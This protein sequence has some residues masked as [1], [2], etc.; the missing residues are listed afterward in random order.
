MMKLKDEIA[1]ELIQSIQKSGSEILI[2]NFYFGYYEFDVFRMLDNGNIYE[3][4]IKTSRADFKNDFTK[5]RKVISDGN[6]IEVGKHEEIKFG[7]YSANK[8]FFVV[9]E[10]LIAPE[11]VPGKLGLIY[12]H[13]ERFTMHPE[14]Y[15]IRFEM[16]KAPKFINKEKIEIDHIGLLRKMAF[17]E[18]NLRLKIYEITKQKLK[19]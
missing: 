5:K 13:K 7:K 2:P 15:L 14:K 17:R 16:V 9:P 10:G 3:Y 6:I 12:F 11:E 4:E 1:F 19:K 8:F 18:M